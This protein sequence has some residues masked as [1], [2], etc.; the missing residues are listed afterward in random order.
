MDDKW[1]ARKSELSAASKLIANDPYE[2]RIVVPNTGKSWHAAAVTL[3]AADQEA[4]VKTEF[5]Q[6]GTRLRVNITSPQSREIKWSVRFEPGLPEAAAPKPVTNLT[7]SVDCRRVTLTWDDTDAF[8]YK[9]T[10]S[11]GVVCNQPYA[12]LMDVKM[13]K[14][15]T[16]F[17]TV[18]G[19]DDSQRKDR[20]CSL[21]H[22]V[23]GISTSNSITGSRSSA[24]S[25][26]MP[27]MASALIM[28]TGWMLASSCRK[29]KLER[30]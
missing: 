27:A 30:K 14:D 6:D 7:A 5:K 16:H 17:V 15:A 22:Y 3:S 11:D 25:S 29:N 24:L 12:N 20:P 19:I 2:L 26:P 9:I 21:H 1:D 23:P 8:T 4:G 28:P 18:V 10:R 13:P